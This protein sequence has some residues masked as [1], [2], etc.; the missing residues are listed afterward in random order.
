M[1]ATVIAL[2]PAKP[3]AVVAAKVRVGLVEKPHW[4][5][6]RSSGGDQVDDDEFTIGLGDMT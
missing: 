1:D 4:V 6:A 2:M 3:G 5:S